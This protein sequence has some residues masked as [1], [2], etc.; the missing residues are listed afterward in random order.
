MDDWFG[1]SNGP[2]QHANISRFRAVETGMP[3]A[4]CA[5][6]GVSVFFDARGRDEGR[7]ALMDSVVL[8]RSIAVPDLATPYA[9]FGGLVDGAF[10]AALAAWTLA[11]LFARGVPGFRRRARPSTLRS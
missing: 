11:A 6:S 4:R 10:L 9:R 3:V 5:N 1:R 2:Y 7:T 8:R